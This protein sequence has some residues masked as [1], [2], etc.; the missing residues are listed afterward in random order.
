MT[1]VILSWLL[2]YRVG[3]LRYLVA[4][5]YLE[6]LSQLHRS[7]TIFFGITLFIALFAS[8]LILMTFGLAMMVPLSTEG[9]GL[10]VMSL[11][12]IIV[13]LSVAGYFILNS[14]RMWIRFLRV[15]S[16]LKRISGERA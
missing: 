15:E 7:V 8:G 5:T 4:K 1:K 12:G 6:T 2:S 3:Q 16:V 11:G 10:I 13:G 14:E 9:R